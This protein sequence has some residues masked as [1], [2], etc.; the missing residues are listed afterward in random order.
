MTWDN[1]QI[2]YYI[3]SLCHR[4]NHS[5]SHSQNH[6]QRQS[7]KRWQINISNIILIRES[8]SSSSLSGCVLQQRSWVTMK[9]K[10]LLMRLDLLSSLWL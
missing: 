5:Q 7:H 1:N 4:Q 6:N 10:T 8:S 9:L 2:I 3:S